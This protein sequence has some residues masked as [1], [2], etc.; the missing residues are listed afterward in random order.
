ME[1]AEDVFFIM[2]RMWDAGDMGGISKIVGRGL[3]LRLRV[4]LINR[5]D[6]INRTEVKE[7]NLMLASDFSDEIGDSV[8]VK[9]W[10]KVREDVGGEVEPF[11]DLWRFSCIEDGGKFWRVEDIEIVM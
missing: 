2:Q 3:E 6:R 11:E 7:L 9:F 4:D 5:G 10:G 8:A 1:F